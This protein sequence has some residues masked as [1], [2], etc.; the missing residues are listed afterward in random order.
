MDMMKRRRISTIALHLVAAAAILLCNENLG[1]A[2]ATGQGKTI[3]TW[4]DATDLEASLLELRAHA[5]HFHSLSLSG[6]GN[7]S[8]SR[9]EKLRWMNIVQEELKINT[10]T[11]VG[12]DVT[13]FFTEKE[14]VKTIA[15]YIDQAKAGGYSGVDLDFEHLPIN[16]SVTQT[17]STFLRSLSEELHKEGLLLSACVGNYPTLSNG[18]R[19]FYDPAVLNET[20]D[21]VRVMNYDMYWV[22]GRGVASLAS[23]PDCA[24]VGPTS[25]QPWAKQSMEWWIARVD[26]DKLVMGLPAY[27]NDYCSLPHYGGGNGTQVYRA[28]PPTV[29]KEA[30][31]GSVESVWQF[32]DQIYVHRYIDAK[33]KQPRI[34][35]GTDVRSTQAHLRTADELGLK[36]VGFWEWNTADEAMMEAVYKWTVS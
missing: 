16:S 5:E 22:G 3:A 19:V 12:G 30:L 7:A 10:Y 14:R 18:I 13:S 32:Y 11:L 2:E 1:F 36:Q 28:G 29:P 6:V 34:R 33:T 25:T 23:R 17:Y 15:K 8:S 20:C 26:S 9:E 27:S 4:Y 31:P 35:Y 24:G 21:V